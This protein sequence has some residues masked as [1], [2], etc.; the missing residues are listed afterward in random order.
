MK[1]Q[2]IVMTRAR[3]RAPKLITFDRFFYGFLP[4]MVSNNR[5]QK[6]AFIIKPG[7]IQKFHKALVKRKYQH[8]YSNKTSK[9]PGRKSPDQAL[10][11]L[12]VKIKKGNPMMGYGRIAMQVSETFGMTISRFAVG[13]ILRKYRHKLPPNG[14]PSWLTFIGQ[15]KDS[16]WSVDLFRCESIQ[17]RSHWVMVV[18]DQYTRRIIGFAVHA[19]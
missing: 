6:V 12:V 10:I 16:L 15:M 13:R 5:L 18:L 19:G 11:E 7:T 2:L 8:L 14:G 9:K 3:S 4:F 1:Q 17:L